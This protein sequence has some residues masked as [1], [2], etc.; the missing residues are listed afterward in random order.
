MIFYFRRICY[1]S[2]LLL[3]GNY[4]LQQIQLT[5]FINHMYLFYILLR[6]PHEN[7]LNF[8]YEIF[9]EICT[10][11]ITDTLLCFTDANS[12]NLE[13]KKLA[14]FFVVAVI[15]IMIIGNMGG[16][17]ILLAIQGCKFIKSKCQRKTRKQDYEVTENQKI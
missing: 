2:V 1:A 8:R 10:L 3:L 17:F 14:G 16:G 15:F 9:N 13:S 4:P 5:I 7:K 6:K 12:N 11:L